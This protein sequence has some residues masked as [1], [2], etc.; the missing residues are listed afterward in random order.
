[1]IRCVVFLQPALPNISIPADKTPLRE[2][3]AKLEIEKSNMAR[4]ITLNSSVEDFN[5]KTFISATE[6]VMVKESGELNQEADCSLEATNY[7][8]LRIKWEIQTS[9]PKD[10]DSIHLTKTHDN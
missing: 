9:G 8:D 6:T 2:K 5:L 3:M 10:N 7:L 1:M 4:L